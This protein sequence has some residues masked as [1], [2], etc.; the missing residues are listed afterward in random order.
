MRPSSAPLRS[1]YFRSYLKYRR[2]FKPALRKKFDADLRKL[3]QRMKQLGHGS[4]MLSDADSFF[5]RNLNLD[6]DDDDTAAKLISLRAA[7]AEL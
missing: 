7:R 3:K 5:G 2:K 4:L 6:D 1:R